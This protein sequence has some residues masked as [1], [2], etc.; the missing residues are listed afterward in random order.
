MHVNGQDACSQ[1]LESA[2]MHFDQGRFYHVESLLS[3]CLKNGFNRQ[4]R[5]NA[6]E[7]LALTKLYLD[8]MDQADSVYLDLLRLDP[9]RKINEQIDPPDLIFL[10]NH[11]RTRPV[12]YWSIIGGINF[13]SP[14]IIHDYSVFDELQTNEQPRARLGFEGGVNIEFNVFRNLY[15]GGEL[16]FLRKNFVYT[17]DVKFESK[18]RIE[19]YKISQIESNS[20][21][22]IPVFVKYMVGEERLRPYFYGGLSVDLLMYSGQS[23]IAKE[24]PI[25]ED[26]VE[27]TSRDITSFRNPVNLS[28]VLGIG[29]MM[30]S[31]GLSLVAMDLKIVPGLTNITK[32]SRRNADQGNMIISGVVSD[33]M[34]INSISLSVRFIRPFYNPKIKKK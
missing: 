5:I 25:E 24:S 10:H 4:E 18:E 7:L 2:Q 21:I 30:K 13:S 27:I 14:T 29:V 1:N 17:D 3:D 22:S 6:L 9:E 31:G 28:G 11:F 16:L 12:F 20:Y 33:A 26:P 23:D 34:R 32:E 19:G 15:V 8:Q